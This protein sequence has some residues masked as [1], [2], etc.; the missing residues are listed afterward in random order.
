[1]VAWAGWCGKSDSRWNAHHETAARIT[2]EATVGGPESVTRVPPLSLS[3][4]L[5]GLV[6]FVRRRRE[7]GG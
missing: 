4:E 7:P 2:F 5:G 1:M 6:G 3:A